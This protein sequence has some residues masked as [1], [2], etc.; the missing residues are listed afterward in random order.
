[1]RYLL[2]PFGPPVGWTPL[3]YLLDVGFTRD[4]D[5]EQADIDAVDFIRTLSGRL[6]GTGVLRRDEQA[7]VRRMACQPAR[8]GYMAVAKGRERRPSMP[9]EAERRGNRPSLSGSQ[10]P[11]SGAR[12]CS[13]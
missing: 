4:V 10:G 5:G 8:T 3:K 12:P 6:P 2:I 9:A 13:D 1:M 7:G 11:T